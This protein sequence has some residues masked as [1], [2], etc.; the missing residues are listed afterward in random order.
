M[1]DTAAA[2]NT[3]TEE[4]TLSPDNVELFEQLQYASGQWYIV[5]SFSG[6]E[7]KVK[8]H[9]EL[10]VRNNDLED[11]VHQ[12]E[13]PMET[14]HVIKDG[15]R[16]AVERVKLPGYV[17][18]RMEMDSPRAWTIVRGTP[19]VTGFIGMGGVPIPLSISEVFDMLK[20]PDVRIVAQKQSKKH[21]EKT[22][23]EYVVGDVVSVV[24]GPF[25]TLTAT[26]SDVNGE[27]QRVTAMVELFGRDT[28]VEL[29][30]NQIKHL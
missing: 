26:I 5:H 19:G 22:A 8:G 15:E 21:G 17:L 4:G 7:R 12:V 2:G 14:V 13:V 1:S 29:R 24:D 28:P 23:V 30:F 9:I 6:H 20:F 25:E 11:E 10:A 16:R 3:A 18:V 27:S